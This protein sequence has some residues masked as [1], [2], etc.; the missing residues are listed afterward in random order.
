MV[1]GLLLDRIHGDCGWP[2]IAEL[3]EFAAFVFANE[4]ESR[5]ALANVAVT[6][7]EITVEASVGHYFPPTRLVRR[8]SL[9]LHGETVYILRGL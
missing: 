6:R 9:V 1:E 2:S 8:Y 7:T 3:N 4:A 5:L